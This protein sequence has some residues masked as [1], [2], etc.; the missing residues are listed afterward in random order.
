MRTVFSVLAGALLFFSCKKDKDDQPA[1]LIP[2]KEGNQWTYT[3][4]TFD[5][6]GNLAR[7]ATLTKVLKG[8]RKIGD[9]TYFALLNATDELDTLAL[10]RADETHIYEYDT[11]FETEVVLFKWP[12]TD[13]E[14][15]FE[16]SIES[17]KLETVVSTKPV[18]INTHQSYTST[19]NIYSG[20]QKVISVEAYVKPG[21]GITGGTTYEL[22]PLTDE[23]YK[24]E[25]ETIVSYQLK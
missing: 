3:V 1:Q 24:S 5:E 22:N 17:T 2:L 20:T 23:L 15:V 19:H 13:G 10:Y 18:T 21:V 12:A 14:V 9:K 8:T 4:K 25:E 6:D 11:D 7:T 16:Q